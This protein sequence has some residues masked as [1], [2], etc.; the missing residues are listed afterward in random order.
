MNKSKSALV[1]LGFAAAS[2]CA[3]PAAGQVYLGGSMATAKVKQACDGVTT[4]CKDKD[5]SWGGFLGYR[6]NPYFG[7]EIGGRNFGKTEQGD[8]GSRTTVRRSVGEFL[9][10][11][12]YPSENW[13]LYVKGGP[14]RAKS[15][16]TSDLG[17]SASSINVAWTLGAGVRYDFATH[18][19]ARLEL[20]RYYHVGGAAIGGKSNIQVLGVSALVSF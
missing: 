13:S 9:A 18:F 20:Q 19:G 5:L 10:V 4:T 16:L 8:P 7:A 15:K 17:M 3:F 2:A 1:I 14:Y 12:S 11:A 6:I